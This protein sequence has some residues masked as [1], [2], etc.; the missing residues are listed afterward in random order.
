[1]AHSPLGPGDN[2]LQVSGQFNAIIKYKD[3]TTEQ[4]V[5]VIQQLTTPLLG[6]LAVEALQL[7]S[8]F[9][10]V[11]GQTVEVKSLYTRVFAGLG[12]LQGTY[13]IKLTE[14]AKPYALSLPCR[15]PIP[16]IDKVKK[17]L[18]RMEALGVIA[19]IDEPKEWCAGIV[20]PLKPNGEVRIGSR[21]NPRQAVRSGG[22]YKT[23]RHSWLLAGATTPRISPP[24]NVHPST[25]RRGSH[26]C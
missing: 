8:T 25:F 6:L 23:R 12:C 2:T 10:S 20:V 7:A 11:Q 4:P 14:D 13:K 22:V 24:D 26:K 9:D 3:Q 5:F 1:M 18:Q 19:P 17:E 16:F 21:R 15:V